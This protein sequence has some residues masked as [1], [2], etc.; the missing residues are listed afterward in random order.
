[1]N[2]IFFIVKVIQRQIVATQ[3]WSGHAGTAHPA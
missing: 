2:A 1:M 3:T